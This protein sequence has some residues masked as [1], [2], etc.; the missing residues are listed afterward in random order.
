MKILMIINE[1]PPTGES[2]V[3]RALKFVKYLSRAGHKVHVITPKK[4]VKTVLDYSLCDDVPEDVV[5]HYT[6]SF[7]LKGSGRD[8][9][10]KTKETVSNAKKN[11]L[12]AFAWKVFKSINDMIFP[13]DKQIGWVPFATAKALEVIKKEKIKTVFITSFPFSAQ[14][15]GLKLKRKLGD[16]IFYI[17]D[18]R[19]SWQF[20]P[21]LEENVNLARLKRIK[22]LDTHI[23]KSCDY[24]TVTTK[25][26]LDEYIELVPP[27]KQKSKLI[28]NGYD[29][30]DFKN[31]KPMKY[32]KFTF[33]YMGKIYDFKRSPLPLMEVLDN[34]TLPFDFQFISIGTIPSQM[35]ETIKSKYDFFS[36]LGYK[37]HHEALEMAS[38]ADVLVI[39]VNNDEK[40]KGVITGKI[41]E[42]IRLN[43]PILAMC[44]SGG[45]LEKLIQDYNLGFAVP[46]DNK[47]LMEEAIQKIVKFTL[48]EETINSYQFSREF[49]ANQLAEIIES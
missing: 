47:K 26:I 36:F 30:D 12:K 11:F 42:Y 38:G 16:R 10:A 5:I 3:Q 25:Q 18:Y 41:F 29:E 19:D 20:E 31:L 39:I 2:G 48:E 49:Q 34:L 22:K 7:G 15:I 46:S 13:Y 37:D 28:L 43:K 14:L 44:P 8:Y 9:I 40:S 21:K 6:A 23:L 1:F 27:L 17:A 24:F 32:N 4:P 45:I 33:F 35:H